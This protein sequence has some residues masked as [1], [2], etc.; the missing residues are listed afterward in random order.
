MSQRER[1]TGRMDTFADI[2]RQL[3]LWARVQDLSVLREPV[4]AF[5]QEGPA[6]AVAPFLG[7]LLERPVTP[8]LRPALL[9][10]VQALLEPGVVSYERAREL[11]EHARDE[12]YQNLCRVLGSPSPVVVTVRTEARA[13]DPLFDE[14]PLGTRKWKARLHDR[15]L[16]ARLVHDPD[17]AVVVIL[18]ANPRLTEAGVLR[19]ASGRPSRPE[20][21]LAVVQSS[22]WLPRRAV[23][24]A[25]VQNPY[26]PL[27]ARVALLPLMTRA[28]LARLKR[29]PSGLVGFDEAVA[30][31]F[32]D[33]G[34]A[35]EEYHQAE[36]SDRGDP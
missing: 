21:L 26:T 15:N 22:R 31:F 9:V 19:L 16:L 34:P 20:R 36:P 1:T 28:E 11:Y 29:N 10:L 25:L 35:A 13:R 24:E 14:V 17:P 12:G 27:P 7:A 5:L 32:P 18:L 8:G 3:R 30:R 6:E 23:I 2:H 4:R 33:C